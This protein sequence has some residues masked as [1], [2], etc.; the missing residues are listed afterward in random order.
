MEA[1]ASNYTV[2]QNYVDAITRTSTQPPLVELEAK[3]LVSKL[4]SLN[5]VLMCTVWNNILDTLSRVNKA[6]QASGI[7]IGS[8][9]TVSCWNT[10]IL[11]MT[12]E[13]SIDSR[14]KQSP[15]HQDFDYDDENKRAKKRKL[16]HDET[17][18]EVKVSDCGENFRMNTYLVIIDRLLSEIKKW[19][20]AYTNIYERF[21]VLT[22]IRSLADNDIT[23]K[24]EEL[25]RYYN[26]DIESD[27]EKEFRLFTKYGD[28][29]TGAEMITFL[30]ENKLI[31]SFPNVHIA[32][33]IYLS[34]FGSSCEGERCF[35]VLK[36]IKDYHRS[37]L[38]ALS[39]LAIESEMM[40]SL[41][42]DDTISS[43]AI[44]KIR[45]VK[46]DYASLSLRCEVLVDF[47][48]RYQPTV[49]HYN[50]CVL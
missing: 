35:S 30:H 4:S 32:L 2:M 9:V 20:V 22:K 23:S 45:K 21:G 27:F 1:L 46:L 19:K 11:C 29:K 24:C 10:S 17:P 36:R 13:G 14:M 48:N 38:S 16:F 44:K 34:I 18:E 7:E 33:R 39:L 28:I 6:L 49:H 41:S 15:L 8:V 26:N 12:Q 40:R 31:T 5:I 25:T 42:V 37:R 43:F 3:S 50:I 47:D